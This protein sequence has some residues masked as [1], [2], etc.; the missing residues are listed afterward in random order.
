MVTTKND[1]NASNNWYLDTW[2]S[3]HM[4]GHKE[5]FVSIDD[6]VKTRVKFADDSFIRAEGMGRVMFQRQNGKTSY[7]ANV[8][9]V[10]KMKNNLL[11]LG[12]LL[13]KGYEMTLEDRMLKVF[14]KKR[15]LIF[16]APLSQNKTFKV[17]LTS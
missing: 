12:Q 14:N 7:I 4:T 3:N 6:S 2:C 11:S 10:P 8:L 16:K 5:W 13:D 9:Y 1:Q 15:V 17:P